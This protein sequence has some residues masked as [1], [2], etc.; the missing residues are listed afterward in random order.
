MRVKPVRLAILTGSVLFCLGLPAIGQEEVSVQFTGGYSTMFGSD[1]AG[2]YTADMNGAPSASG[3]ICDD[4]NDEITP[5]EGWTAKAY[6]A[7]SLASGNLDSTLFGSTIGLTGYAEVATLVSM[8]FGNSTSYAGINGISQSEISS[9]IWY[10]TTS[11]GISGLDTKALSLVSAVE[12]AFNG[13]AGKAQQYLATLTN[14][15]ILTPTQGEPSRPQEVWAVMVVAV[16]EGGATLVYLLLA[17][18]TC[19]GA[20][21]FRSKRQLRSSATI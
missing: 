1:G 9:A 7:S 20:I 21:F 4:Y 2:I 14:L 16:P 15:W 8:M 3:I 19:F 5:G 6:Q 17:G 12:R 11:G 18:A 10:L 13:N